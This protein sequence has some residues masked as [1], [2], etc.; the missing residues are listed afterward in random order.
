[1]RRQLNSFHCT[2]DTQTPFQRIIVARDST[3]L[4]NAPIPLLLDESNWRVA[5][6]S[7]PRKHLCGP[8]TIPASRCGVDEAARRV[9]AT[10]RDRDS[11]IRENFHSD[12][13]D[14]ANYDLVLNVA[15]LSIED[16]V[17]FVEQGLKRLRA[18]TAAKPTAGPA[19]AVCGV[20]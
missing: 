3:V 20:G 5:L 12:P 13:T 4:I 17:D 8:S 2:P 6:S 18:R 15:R 9:E 16:C 7:H 19:P 14:P 10:D 11:F 1:L